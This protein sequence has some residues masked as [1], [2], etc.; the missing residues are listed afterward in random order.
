MQ[1][2]DVRGLAG[3]ERADLAA[4]L[5]TLT[6]QQWQAPTLCT[7][8]LVRDVAAHVISYDNVGARAIFG[9]A[10]HAEFRPG[11]INDTA[12]SRYDR[13]TPSS[14]WPCSPAICSPAGSPLRWA[15]APAW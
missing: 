13:H 3:D 5:A 7:R 12:L 2:V 9:V 10:A 8:W 14:C 6:P 11:R 1:A 4:F 15:A